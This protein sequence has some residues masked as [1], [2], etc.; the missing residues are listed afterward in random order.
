[1]CPTIPDG[2]RSTCGPTPAPALQIS[3]SGGEEPLW[4]GKGHELCFRRGDA[5][6]SVQLVSAGGRLTAGAAKEIFSGALH[7]VRTG[8]DVS[9][10]GRTFL[11]LKLMQPRENLSQ[12]TLVLNGLAAITTR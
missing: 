10:D 4:V 3:T 7:G 6:M 5:I 9:A 11:L 1:M 2:M 8:Y 12:F